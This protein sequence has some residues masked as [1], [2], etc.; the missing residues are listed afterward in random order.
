MSGIKFKWKRTRLA[1][2]ETPRV[3]ASI[4]NAVAKPTE[5]SEECDVSTARPSHPK[6]TT[7]PPPLEQDSDPESVNGEQHSLE[8]EDDPAEV[9]LLKE[10]VAAAVAAAQA[11]ARKARQR[12]REETE[13]ASSSIRSS[14]DHQKRSSI[15]RNHHHSSHDHHHQQQRSK[16]A[17]HRRSRSRSG[18]PSSRRQKR[19]RAVKQSPSRHRFREANE[20]KKKTTT[21]AQTGPQPARS[22]RPECL[23]ENKNA[24]RRMT[25]SRFDS[26]QQG[27]MEG[28]T[29]GKATNEPTHNHDG[30]ATKT[31]GKKWKNGNQNRYRLYKELTG[32]MEDEEDETG[33][34]AVVIDKTNWRPG[35]E[36][37]VS[38]TDQAGNLTGSQRRGKSTVNHRSF[39]GQREFK[40][41]YVQGRRRQFLKNA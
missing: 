19:Q 2:A 6:T 22:Y 38:V 30:N 23:K 24:D 21:N 11:L 5:S 29:K 41:G 14:P 20:R 17:Y 33:T 27:A 36:Q 40:P 26:H 32:N 1:I 10:Q 12:V 35:Q 3:F 37:V 31:A 7:E 28:M 25:G 4:N 13:H 9:S 34:G 39:G 15:A 16:D 8:K 18:S